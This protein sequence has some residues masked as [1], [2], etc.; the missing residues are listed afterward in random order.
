MAVEAF[1][2][3]FKPK[4]CIPSSAGYIYLVQIEQ[5]L[6]TDDSFASESPNGKLRTSSAVVEI[7]ATDAA[8]SDPGAGTNQH[9]FKMI[10]AFR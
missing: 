3:F 5:H 9:L 2:S 8:N 10:T 6:L 7:D 1:N 4:F